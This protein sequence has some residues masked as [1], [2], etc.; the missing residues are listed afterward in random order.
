MCVTG[1]IGITA[2]EQSLKGKS[3]RNIGI[4]RQLFARCAISPKVCEYFFQCISLLVAIIIQ[5]ISHNI[6]DGATSEQK[7]KFRDR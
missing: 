6:R 2:L 3:F 4:V 7:L 1:L 5:E